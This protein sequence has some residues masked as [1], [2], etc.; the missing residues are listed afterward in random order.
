MIWTAIGGRQGG[1]MIWTAI[2]GAVER[3]N[4]NPRHGGGGS[5][6]QPF[7]NIKAKAADQ[8]SQ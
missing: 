7:K 6:V 5:I 2:G 3:A 8:T 4:E 1:G